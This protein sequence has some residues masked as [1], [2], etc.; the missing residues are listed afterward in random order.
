[1]IKL[2]WCFTLVVDIIK[3]YYIRI[4][5]KLELLLGWVLSRLC[6]VCLYCAVNLWG[7]WYLICFWH[8]TVWLRDTI[9]WNCFRLSYMLVYINDDMLIF[10][11]P[12]LMRYFN[13]YLLDELF[14]LIY[15]LKIYNDDHVWWWL[16]K[17]MFLVFYVQWCMG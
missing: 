9:F 16:F 10:I 8:L 15:N 14:I 4:F 3:L 2:I 13:D 6:L 12:L 5:V 11:W 17:K 7:Q 1:M